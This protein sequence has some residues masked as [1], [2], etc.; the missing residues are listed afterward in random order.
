MFAKAL[1]RRYGALPFLECLIF[2]VVLSL[3]FSISTPHFLSWANFI[4]ILTANAVIGLMAFGATFVIAGGGIDLS[5]AAVMAFSGIVGAVLA[6]AGAH[7]LVVLA[8]AI[9]AGASFGVMNGFLITVSGAPSFVITLGT[10]SVARALSF[11]I[12]GGTPIYGLPSPIVQFGQGTIFNIA[13]P[14]WIVFIG[15]LVALYILSSTRFGSHTLIY[16]DNP[17]AA[18]ASGIPVNRLRVTMFAL[19]GAFSGIAGFVFMARTNSGDPTAGMNY[20]LAAITAVILGGANLFGGRA[21]M[22]GTVIGILSLGVLQN[23]LNLLAVGT[24][25]QIL[26]VGL[27]LIG[28]ALLRKLDQ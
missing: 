27:V 21:S 17:V 23:G 6:Q 5:T 12:T 8:A 7:P 24:F 13:L 10:M 9:V 18:L 19:A 28:A 22:L 14:V 25:Y 11:I 3:G 2:L 4:N 15:A 1:K 20:E 26:F 16:G